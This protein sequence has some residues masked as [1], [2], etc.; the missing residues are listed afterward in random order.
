MQEWSIDIWKRN[1]QTA[2]HTPRN[3][4]RIV[5][6]W[7][8]LVYSYI[9]ESHSVPGQ[10]KQIK[11]LN[12]EITKSHIRSRENDLSMGKTLVNIYNFLSWVSWEWKLLTNY[13]SSQGKKYQNEV[14]GKPMKLRHHYLQLQWLA[15][16]SEK[17]FKD[18]NNKNQYFPL[19]L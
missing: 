16:N 1:Y 15:L 14:P 19:L 18:M 13:L 9:N 11:W 7:W 12:V 10:Q 6:E 8:N 4:C 3:K 17:G 2:T 5:T